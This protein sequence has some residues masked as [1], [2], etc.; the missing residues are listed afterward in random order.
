MSKENIRH[1]IAKQD[2]LWAE[3]KNLLSENKFLNEKMRVLNMNLTPE[4]K[5]YLKKS[6]FAFHL[7]IIEEFIVSEIKDFQRYNRKRFFNYF[8]I[9]K[10]NIKIQK[11]ITLKKKA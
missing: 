2:M 6:E 5:E 10:T 7:S 3:W 8:N 4:E 9:E 11:Y 1:L